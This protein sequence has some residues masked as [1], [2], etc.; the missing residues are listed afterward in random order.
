MKKIGFEINNKNIN[1][2]IS[3]IENIKDNKEIKL[4]LKEEIQKAKD[5][6][7]FYRG[8]SAKRAVDFILEKYEEIKSC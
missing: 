6:A 1:E 5:I 4:K 3:L 8:E 2:I 7:W